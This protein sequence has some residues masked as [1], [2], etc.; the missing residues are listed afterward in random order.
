MKCP[1]CQKSVPNDS[2]FCK[3]CGNKLDPQPLRQ[4]IRPKTHNPNGTG[5]VY[6]RGSTWTAVVRVA[7]K[8]SPSENADRQ[9]KGLPPTKTNF[10]RHSK[11]GFKTKA[12]AISYLPKLREELVGVK[13][14]DRLITMC[15]YYKIVQ[16]DY[17]PTVTDH[18]QKTY[19]LAWTRL[20]QL[21]NKDIR[22]LTVSDLRETV[23]S[24]CKARGAINSAKSL[25]TKIYT[26][27]AVDGICNKDLPSFIA[28]PEKEEKR[29]HPLHS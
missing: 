23:Y 4:P 9:L 3:H 28:L 6:R 22:D 12:Q 26:L 15:E 13:K 16:S 11:G 21:H 8:A 18:V 19:E 7:S 5:S 10:V 14:E 29:T 24:A 20:S 1:A 27:A 2:L 25:L 17:F